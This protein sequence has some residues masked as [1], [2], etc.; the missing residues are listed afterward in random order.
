MRPDNII[1]FRREFASDLNNP[2]DGRALHHRYVLVFALQAG[3]TVYVDDRTI[4][5][6]TGEGLLILPFQFHRY[7][8]PT[9]YNINWLFVTFDLIDA[10]SQQLL[11][12][13]SFVM[14]ASVRQL[15]GELIEAYLQPAEEDLTSLLLAL[16]LAR[17]R[18]APATHHSLGAVPSPPALMLQVNH[19]VQRRYEIRTVHE[20]AQS[21]GISES[22]LRA[23]F[24]ASCG[25]SVCQH[26][27]RLR[28]EKA[29]GLLRLTTNGI[30]EIS[31]QCG[32]TSIYN[33]SRT[34]REAFGV[35]PRSYRNRTRQQH[36]I[37]NEQAVAC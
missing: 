25:V 10:D 7:S 36:K 31:D 26:L 3:A 6:N 13:N 9:S 34:F 1:C 23:R 14:T 17:V 15:A 32:F 24:R 12:Y 21:L 20:I 11:R 29:S 35:S 2:R 5:L 18:Q 27:R 33:F 19:L 28:L 22:H 16:L 30:T 8:D 37:V 4:R